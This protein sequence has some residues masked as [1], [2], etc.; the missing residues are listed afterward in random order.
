MLYSAFASASFMMVSK[1][2]FI[3]SYEYEKVRLFAIDRLRCR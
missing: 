1:I 2:K 3:L